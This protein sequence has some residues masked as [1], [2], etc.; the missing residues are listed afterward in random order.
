MREIGREGKRDVDVFCEM[1]YRDLRESVPK[2]SFV[3]SECPM[4]RLNR[5]NLKLKLKLKVALHARR[6]LT[7]L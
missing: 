2:R 3:S 1:R 7:A 6:R 4:R 5:V